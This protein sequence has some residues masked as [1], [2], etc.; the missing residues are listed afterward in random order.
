MLAY[1]T[2]F[3]NLCLHFYMLLSTKHLS[4]L[5]VDWK[6]TK[7]RERKTAKK[8]KKNIVAAVNRTRGSCMAS[9]NFTTKPL[10]LDVMT[11]HVMW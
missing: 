5:I 8:S 7:S 10:R 11:Y 4:F 2:S 3:Y 6:D 9:T 1:M